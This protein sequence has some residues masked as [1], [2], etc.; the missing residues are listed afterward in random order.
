VNDLPVAPYG[1]TIEDGYKV[2]VIM[3]SMKESSKTGKSI[4]ITF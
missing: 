4:D 2:Q 3:E 1:A